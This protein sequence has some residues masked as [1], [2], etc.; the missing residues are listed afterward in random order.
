MT[1]LFAL[2]SAQSIIE[3]AIETAEEHSGRDMS[4]GA[5][6]Q[7]ERMQDVLERITAMAD[8]LSEQVQ[9]AYAEEDL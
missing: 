8:R 2:R 3:E 9:A 7:A 4:Q 6:K 1:D 5:R